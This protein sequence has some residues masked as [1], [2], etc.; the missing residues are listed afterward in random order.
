MEAQRERGEEACRSRHMYS[1]SLGGR[2]RVFGTSMKEE[3][4]LM[5]GGVEGFSDVIGA[6]GVMVDG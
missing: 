4:C 5:P 6:D 3:R 2:E 1:I